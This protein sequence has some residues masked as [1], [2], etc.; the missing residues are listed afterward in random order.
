MPEIVVGLNSYG[1]LA[2]ADAYFDGSQRAGARWPTLTTD[3][4]K[5]S[6]ISAFRILDRQV[7]MGTKVENLK[8][9]TSFAVAAGGTGWAA[10]DTATIDG[11]G[12]RRARITVLTVSAGAIVTARLDDAGLYDS[13]PT[14]PITAVSPSAGAGA[15]LTLTTADNPASFPRSDIENCADEELTDTDFPEELKFGQFELAY[16]ISVSAAA[17]TN[18]GIGSNLRSVKA[19]T[20]NVEFFRPTGGVGGAGSARFPIYV[21]EYIGCFLSGGSGADPSSFGLA[22]GMGSQSS[23]ADPNLYGIDL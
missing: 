12:G 22:A 13:V 23:V 11:T 1:S 16:D 15:S 8:V 21:M 4:R 19:D 5:R 17:E 3:V 14:G 7:W 18:A 20:V 2:E 10:N 9:V 6:L